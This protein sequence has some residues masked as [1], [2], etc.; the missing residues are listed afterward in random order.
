MAGIQ[1]ITED[2]VEIEIDEPGPLVQEEG[3]VH[4]HFFERDQSLFELGQQSLLL[5]PPLVEASPP[6]LAF[7]VADKRH[8]VRAGNYFL[9]VNVIE[10][11]ADAYHLVFDAL[12]D[13]RL[14]ALQLPGEQPEPEFAIEVLSDDL[15]VLADLEDDGF[16]VPDDRHAVVA[17]SGQPPDQG[18]VT[19]GN[20][21]SCKWGAR[22]LQDAALDEAEGTP[23]KL[24][25]FNHVSRCFC[26][27]EGTVGRASR[28]DKRFVPRGRGARSANHLLYTRPIGA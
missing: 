22:E 25:E 23:L 17:L 12:P 20:V 10:L 18:A 2:A 7:F 11:E 24:N 14:Y 6:I 1:E 3:P 19:A 27:N 16:A 5:R 8:L 15:G 9:P 28:A 4:Q 13:Q 21:G 26:A